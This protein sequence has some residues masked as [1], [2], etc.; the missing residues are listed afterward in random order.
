MV[1]GGKRVLIQKSKINELTRLSFKKGSNRTNDNNQEKTSSLFRR[2]RF[3]SDGGEDIPKFNN[4]EIVGSFKTVLNDSIKYRYNLKKLF[5]VFE[6]N[7]ENFRKSPEFV[8][9]IDDI[10]TREKRGNLN[11]LSPNEVVLYS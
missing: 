1:L 6:E 10:C 4:N 9:F 5:D 7:T 8:N 11:I 3:N 2:K